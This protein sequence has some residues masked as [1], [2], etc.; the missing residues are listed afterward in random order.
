MRLHFCGSKYFFSDESGIY[1]WPSHRYLLRTP[2]KTRLKPQKQPLELF[3]KKGI[4]RNFVNFTGKHL[5]WNFFLIE[6]QEV[7]SF[8]KK[9]LRHRCFSK[10]FTKFLRTPNLKIVNDCFWNMFFNLSC[11]FSNLHFWPKL[12]D[13]FCI[14]IYHFLYQYS[15]LCAT[16]DNAIFPSSHPVLF[17]KKGDLTSFA[18]LTRKHEERDSGTHFFLRILQNFS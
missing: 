17:C 14:I 18:K 16:I 8:I 6:L 3:C 4:L 9:R 12:I 13:S 10:E 15:T 5:C 7:C 2:S 11:L 1:C